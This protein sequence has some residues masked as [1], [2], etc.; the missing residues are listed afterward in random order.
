MYESSLSD[1]L[2]LRSGTLNE[3][4]AVAHEALGL[5]LVFS[6][7][8][9]W[10]SRQEKIVR[11]RDDETFVVE[12]RHPAEPGAGARLNLRSLIISIIRRTLPIDSFH[13]LFVTW[14]YMYVT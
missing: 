4:S 8:V 9:H 1:R 2:N 6:R 13:Y 5:Q 7:Y 12:Q 10:T 14:R 11:L 3:N